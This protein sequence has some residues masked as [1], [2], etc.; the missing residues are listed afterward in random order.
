M[1]SPSNPTS[2]RPVAGQSTLQQQIA[3][4]EA[5]LAQLRKDQTLLQDLTARKEELQKELQRV[6]GHIARLAGKVG[7]IA[8]A[9][10]DRP[11]APARAKPAPAKPAGTAKPATAPATK[12]LAAAKGTGQPRLAD[13]ILD[14][15]KGAKGKPLTV[16][17]LTDESMKRGFTTTSSLPYKVVESRVQELSKKGMVARSKDQ[18]G[19]VLTKAPMAPVAKAPAPAA[20]KPSKPAV[21]GKAQVVPKDNPPAKTTLR[22]EIVSVLK[23]SKRPLP[24]KELTERILAGGYQT[25]STDFANVLGVALKKLENVKRIPGEGYLLEGPKA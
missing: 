10:P 13:L 4:L 2:A 15:L 16:R 9:S 14:S 24:L 21:N 23:R 25:V 22:A 7:H 20:A 11:T 19:W 8:P 18:P 1:S 3:Q 17:Q 5:Q 6:N 12:A